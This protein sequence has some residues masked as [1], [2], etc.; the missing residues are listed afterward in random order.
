MFP[1]QAGE[2]SNAASGTAN[3]NLRGLGAVR[4][5]TLVNGRRLPYGSSQISSPNLD[6]IPSQLVERIDLLTGGASAVYGSDAIGGVANFILKDDFEGFELDVQ[7]GFSQA[8]NSRSV[9]ADVLEAGGQPV[10][11]STT[12]GENAILSLTWGK[13]FADGRG[14]ICLLYT[15]PSPRDQR[16]SRMPSSA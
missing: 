5:L 1:G 11:G 13:N 9:F 14:N 10:P 6:L 16:G 7:A 15:S 8:D 12:D 4:T 2:V 3:L